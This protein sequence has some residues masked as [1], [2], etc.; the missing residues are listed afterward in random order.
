MTAPASPFEPQYRWRRIALGGCLLA[1][2]LL[3]GATQRGVVIDAVL[4]VLVI[5]SST[6]VLVGGVRSAAGRYGAIFF[7]CVL[8]IAII[9]MLPLP[10]TMLEWVRP[11][12]LLPFAP[13]GLPPI[14][15]GTISLS[16]SRTL[17]AAIFALV[18]ILFF[19]AA[20]SMP[21]GSL[22]GLIPFFMIGVV[23]NLIAASLQYSSSGDTTLGNLLGYSVAVGLFANQNHFSTLIFSSIP[24]IIYFGFFR[25]RPAIATGLLGLMFLV[26]LAAGSRAGILIGIG[27]FALSIG[28]LIWRGR[29]GTVVVLA[30]F[31]I[32]LVYGYGAAVHVGAEALDA[33]FGRQQFAMTTIQGI[34]QN[35]VTGT[36]FGTFD[37]AYPFYEKTSMIYDRYVNHAHNDFLEVLLEG[38]IAAGAAMLAYALL[39]AR[40]ALAVGTHA[41]SRLTM[42]AII[43]ILLHSAVD[44]PLR[45]MAIAM[46]FAFFNALL[47]SDLELELAEQRR[48]NNGADE[49]QEVL[50][51]TA[52][53][54]G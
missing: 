28:S 46:T 24:L 15:A 1:S 2:L 5:A 45:T 20:S 37:L 51:P 25:D 34:L 17:E 10:V 6:Y 54:A 23:C 18:P 38:G 11:G 22:S 8:A 40:R 16:V 43:V 29:I 19:I 14:G 27:V 52:Q 31:G 7:V 41:L 13:A 3:G 53:Q 30:L 36:G 42:I 35:W 49:R 26:L 32:L 50:P 4:Q 48:H 33:D 44:Y 39:T 12:A 21:R 9:Q 47:F